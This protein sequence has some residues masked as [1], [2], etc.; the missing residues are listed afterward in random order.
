MAVGT[1]KKLARPRVSTTHVSKPDTVL[2]LTL[3]VSESE[4]K[5][6]DRTV[7]EKLLKK[8]KRQT[9]AK[10]TCFLRCGQRKGSLRRLDGC[11]IKTISVPRRCFW[12]WLAAKRF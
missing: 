3:K 7:P 12:F 8:V 2:R 10:A 1:Q 5:L 11:G 9:E 6:S 4:K